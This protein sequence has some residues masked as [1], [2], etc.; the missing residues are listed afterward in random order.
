M[1][2]IRECPGGH[3]LER[4]RNRVTTL[5]C[6]GPC[7]LGL[8]EL[9]WRWSCGLCDYDICETCSDAMCT[10]PPPSA[11]P[12]ATCRSV[13]IA[14]AATIASKPA[15]RS[16]SVGPMR[17]PSEP[18]P[19]PAT[20]AAVERPSPAWMP[21]DETPVL[22]TARDG[23]YTS[24]IYMAP[25][26]DSV[27]RHLDVAWSGSSSSEHA[28][29]AP[30]KQRSKTGL[31]TPQLAEPDPY[32]GEELLAPKVA[33]AAAR[34]PVHGK[35]QDDAD[36]DASSASSCWSKPHMDAKLPS[37]AIDP[38]SGAP[39][40]LLE[41]LPP[42]E[43]L[44]LPPGAAAHMQTRREWLQHLLT[45]EVERASRAATTGEVSAFEAAC[46]VCT[47]EPLPP[48]RAAAMMAATLH[49]FEEER[50]ELVRC[51]LIEIQALQALQ[52]LQAAGGH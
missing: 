36:K 45:D 19:A 41:G 22:G 31:T 42:L 15:P 34:L 47:A 12:T 7:G 49:K 43:W 5:R 10:A 3:N 32:E 27:K 23:P 52:A 38:E 44:N 6:D 40:S 26:L 13:P 30:K 2:A 48:K 8:K 9:A 18:T 35:D 20:A 4:W 11:T 39:P 1:P 17:P 46:G 24:S 29:P 14:A 37:L 25:G 16:A 21:P 28:A 33:S 51:E 50:A